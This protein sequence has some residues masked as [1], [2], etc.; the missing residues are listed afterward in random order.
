MVD[1]TLYISAMSRI[2]IGAVAARFIHASY[3]IVA[4]ISVAE[5]VGKNQIHQIICIDTALTCRHALMQRV[6]VVIGSLFILLVLKT[7]F[8]CSR[9]LFFSYMDFNQ[10]IIRIRKSMYVLN[11]CVC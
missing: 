6:V 4:C 3:Y 11:V 1:D 5:A 10:N 9:L 2:A 7:K 8:D